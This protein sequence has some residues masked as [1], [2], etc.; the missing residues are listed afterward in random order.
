MSNTNDLIR[1]ANNGGCGTSCGI[2]CSC[3]RVDYPC[4]WSCSYNKLPFKYPEPY[5]KDDIK[6]VF[7]V[8]ATNGEND[9]TP[10]LY[11]NSNDSPTNFDL[12]DEETGY[13]ILNG[14]SNPCEFCI[15]GGL[16]WY[17]LTGYTDVEPNGGVA[18]EEVEQGVTIVLA[19]GY[20]CVKASVRRKIVPCE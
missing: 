4:V 16:Y 19:S 7:L 10:L 1:T 15:D 2:G 3:N 6:E 11:A 9:T 13:I 14:S 8:I 20:M 18:G 17:E 5:K 12:S